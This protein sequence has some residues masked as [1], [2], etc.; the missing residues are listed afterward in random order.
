MYDAYFGFQAPPFSIT[1]N[2]EVFYENPLYREAAISLLFSVRH[3]RR[4][5]L[6]TGSSGTGKTTL[7]RRVASQ[8]APLHQ[9]LDIPRCPRTF[10]EL[11]TTPGYYRGGQ[12][13]IS[14][15]TLRLCDILELCYHAQERLIIFL[16][17][18]QQLSDE[19]LVTLNLL[20][21]LE[22]LSVP[23]VTLVLIGDPSL[24]ARF[25]HPAL[26]DFQKRID[27]HL[28]LQAL[29][30]EETEAYILYRLRA[31][32]CT[33]QGLFS[34]EAIQ[35]VAYYSKGNP[36]LVNLFCDHTLQAAHRTGVGSVSAQLI[37]AVVQELFHGEHKVS[38]SSNREI[39][40]A[41]LSS[42]QT[43]A[44]PT[45]YPVVVKQGYERLA[46]AA[47]MLL[48]IW[49][50]LFQ[51]SQPLQL[52]PRD[53]LPPDASPI[54]APSIHTAQPLHPQ[55][56]STQLTEAQ[57]ARQRDEQTARKAHD[58]FPTPGLEQGTAQFAKAE[59][60]SMI[61]KAQDSAAMLVLAHG[62]R[63]P[64]PASRRSAATRSPARNSARATV[65][66][67]QEAA[68]PQPVRKGLPPTPSNLLASVEHG[69]MHAVRL[70]L[71]AGISPN[72][73]D[74]RGWTPLM[75]AAR[76]DRQELAS[77]LLAH[78]AQVNAKNK[79]GATALIIAAMNNRSAMTELLIDKGARLEEHNAQGWT[80][81]MYA[82]WKGHGRVVSILLNK[83]ARIHATDHKGWTPLQYASWRRDTYAVQE[84]SQKDIAETLGIDIQAEPLT[85]S[86]REDYTEVAQLLRP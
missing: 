38:I 7:A 55:N 30:A 21:N 85:V 43:S 59:H 4:L 15:L 39:S 11:L 54:A 32:G 3:A 68:H 22:T 27:L 80:A 82:A 28:R 74:G 48:V 47:L 75:L 65:A 83:G 8:L 20:L 16:D 73:Q 34:P 66:S 70:L 10:E 25:H 76:D 24:E 1:T 2:P 41:S 17:E 72:I 77:L 23:L 31:A 12:K 14:P 84:Q 35:Q 46:W 29:H 6:L 62:Q 37:D 49:F 13:T 52:T 71:D 42:S 79:T 53:P 9:T 86:S 51:S 44:Q 67:Q 81:L 26:A 63:S 69:D 50:S 60:A 33:R 57:Q 58:S 18:A 61:W 45:A 64:V 36:R 40:D 5:I 78:G 56:A 19:A